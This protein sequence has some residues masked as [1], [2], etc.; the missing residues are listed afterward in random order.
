MIILIIKYYKDE[1]FTAGFIAK[2]LGLKSAI[3]L[4]RI[5]ER[6]EIQKK[7]KWNG[8]WIFHSKYQ[9]K[10]YDI[11]IKKIISNNKEV[12]TRKFTWDGFQFIKKILK[13]NNL[14]RGW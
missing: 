4:N 1:V 12:L 14:Y 3:E 2:K 11:L 9:G 13:E 10:K 8:L 5:L 6:L 7:D